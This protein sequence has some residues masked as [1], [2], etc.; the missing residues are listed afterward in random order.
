M[1]ALHTLGILSTSFVRNAFPTVLKEFPHMLSPCRLLFLHS[2]V[3]LISNHLNWVE[4]RVIVEAR[5]SDAA[6]HHSSCS[7]S[8]Y[9]VWRCVLGHQQST[10]T[11]SHLL[12]HASLWEPHIQEI[13][14]SPTLHLTKTLRLAPK[15]SNLYFRPKDRFPPV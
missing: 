1:T 3:H 9:T 5:S 4:V 14:Q 12:L 7:N 2:V 11:P 6:L 15:I 10:T 8:P 13:I